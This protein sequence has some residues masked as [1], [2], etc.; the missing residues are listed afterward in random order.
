MKIEIGSNTRPQMYSDTLLNEMPDFYKWKIFIQG[1]E[2][3]NN[4]LN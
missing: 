1:V 3:H 2:K 4:N